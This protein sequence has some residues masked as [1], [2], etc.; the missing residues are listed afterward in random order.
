MSDLRQRV[1]L[2]SLLFGCLLSALTLSISH[3]FFGPR[4][5]EAEDAEATP[6]W[7]SDANSEPALAVS[8]PETNLSSLDAEEQLRNLLSLL[9]CNDMDECIRHAR[10]AG[11]PLSK[12]GWLA[13]CAT[14]TIG[15]SWLRDVSL[16]RAPLAPPAP[17]SAAVSWE[18]LRPRPSFQ[19]AFAD[20]NIVGL[21][22]TG[23]TQLYEILASHPNVRRL[24]PNR[25]ENCAVYPRTRRDVV[26]DAQNDLD[27]E[28]RKLQV[29]LHSFVQSM[30]ATRSG[31]SSS[32][33]AAPAITLN[34]CVNFASVAFTWY[35]LR[36]TNRKFILM[37]RDPADWLWSSWNFFDQQKHLD[38]E[39]LGR[40]GWVKRNYRSPE[41]FHELLTSRS[42]TLGGQWLVSW[43]CRSLEDP[44]LLMR[45]VGRS[46]ILFL[47]NEDLVPSRINLKGGLLEKVGGF[48]GISPQKFDPDTYSQIMN[49]NNKKGFKSKCD[50]LTTAYKVSGGRSLLPETRVVIYLQFWEQCN[51]WAVEFGIVYP[52]C[53]NVINF[54]APA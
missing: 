18:S 45:M 3:T 10:T 19:E 23:T 8:G 1:F 43:R 52:D 49:C 29:N 32:P 35:Y 5:G 46:S 15:T 24:N 6:C 20:L 38:A 39:G 14:H 13:R 27:K 16:C 7:Q 47:R 34:G 41:L 17:R 22:K 53:L 40:N 42:Q 25:K 12:R 9:R 51:I 31:H 44:R 36:P 30:A 48:L 11:V 2:Q 26:L 37:F 28:K 21:P 4:Y 54:T 33:G 50:N